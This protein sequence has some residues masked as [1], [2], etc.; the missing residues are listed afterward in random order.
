MEH[1]YKE[2]SGKKSNTMDYILLGAVL[3][4]LLVTGVQAI[5]AASASGGFHIRGSSS[6]QPAYSSQPSANSSSG[7]APSGY[8]Q[9]VGGC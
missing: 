7:A 4:L 6:S 1:E 5:Q 8:P 2:K 9:Q 3:L